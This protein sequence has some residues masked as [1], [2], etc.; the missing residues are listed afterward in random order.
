MGLAALCGCARCGV[1][2]L[3]LVRVLRTVVVS[4]RCTCSLQECALK[5]GV[6]A[7]GLLHYPTLIKDAAIHAVMLCT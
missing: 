4:V 7:H 5:A 6:G 3:C 1:V 2:L